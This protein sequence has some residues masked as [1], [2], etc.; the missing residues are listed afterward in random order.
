VFRCSR[1]AGGKTRRRGAT[2]T[3]RIINIVLKGTYIN[4]VIIII[5]ISRVELGRVVMVDP[6]FVCASR[7]TNIIIAFA[8]VAEAMV[9][10]MVRQRKILN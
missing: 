7:E 2:N 1:R 4:I 3:A 10:V 5:V 6:M 9:I 8:A